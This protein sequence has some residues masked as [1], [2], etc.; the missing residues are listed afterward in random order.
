MVNGSPLLTFSVL[1]F[2]NIQIVTTTA[3]NFPFIGAEIHPIII[4]FVRK[5]FYTLKNV[6][7]VAAIDTLMF[8]RGDSLSKIES[9]RQ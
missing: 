3:L 7:D 2:P 9:Y 6:C 5:Y 8:F 1:V 4:Q